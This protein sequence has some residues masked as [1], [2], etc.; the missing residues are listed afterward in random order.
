MCVEY[1]S[2]VR[3]IDIYIYILYKRNNQ[4][5]SRIFYEILKADI[6]AYLTRVFDAVTTLHQQSGSLTV[7]KVCSIKTLI[8]IDIIRM[9]SR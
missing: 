1:P 3:H 9:R 2:H 5:G 6:R 4:R 8:L 7:S